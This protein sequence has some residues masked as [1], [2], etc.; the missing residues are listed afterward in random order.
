MTANTNTSKGKCP[1][2]AVVEKRV[3]AASHEQASM[4]EQVSAQLD[5]LAGCVA[6]DTCNAI[7]GVGLVGNVSTLCQEG[8]SAI[9]TLER[10]LALLSTLETRLQEI[11]QRMQEVQK[12]CLAIDD[13]ASQSNL[14][15]VNATIEAARLGESGAAFRVVAHGIREMASSS[16]KA[17]ETI[18]STITRGA[19]EIDQ[20][21]LA[22]KEINAVN[23]QAGSTCKE[24]FSDIYNGV[25]KIQSNM[26]ESMSIAKRHE[27][28]TRD[29]SAKLRQH[30]EDNSRTSCEIIGLL[31]GEP[32]VNLSPR[33]SSRGIHRYQVIDV[34]RLDEF[35]AELGH[36]ETA[37]LL[38]LDDHF[39]AKLATYPKDQAYLF[40]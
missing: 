13:L 17:A 35:N 30:A 28:D 38:T 15:A 22:A 31:T 5:T 29:I 8:D 33:E 19:E 37:T 18:H 10:S 9:E 32:I 4:L 12:E 14:L 39:S 27:S 6:K 36:I 24:V 34:R 21:R 16:K 1:D 20:V 25:D 3:R 40:T 2:S 23:S 7:T 26:N 11:E